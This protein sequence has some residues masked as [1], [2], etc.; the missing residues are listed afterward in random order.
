MKKATLLLPCLMLLAPIAKAQMTGADIVKK[1]L[2]TKNKDTVA[3]THSGVFNL[4]ANEGFLHNWSAGGELA[5]LAVSSI[6]QGDITRL[7]HRSIWTND[8]DLAYG[9]FYAYSN[10]FVPRK[11]DDR[12][13]FT[14]KYGYRIDT[15]KD[16]YLTGLFNFRSQFTKGYDYTM[17]VWDTTSTSNFFAPAYL[18]LAPGMEYRKGAD[19]SL[20]FS[21]IAARETF[22]SRYYT[23]R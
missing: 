13:D 8:L 5:S 2:D 17:P 21:P 9:L 4:G 11:T 23:V 7:Y 19:L 1:S 10:S 6:F 3:W 14:S 15:T 22:A 18:T 12:I 16:F 20:F